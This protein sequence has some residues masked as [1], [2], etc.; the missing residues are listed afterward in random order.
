MSKCKICG[1]DNK[2]VG[3]N[4]L[5]NNCYE[6][7]SKLEHYLEHPEG[8]KRALKLLGMNWKDP[9]ETQPEIDKLIHIIKID[10]FNQEHLVFGSMISSG[11]Y[12][13]D[14]DFILSKYIKLWMSFPK[15]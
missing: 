6:V 11:L 9:K 1:I 4:D 7:D 13:I 12:K 14:G 10:Q 8:R 3:M 5:C 15:I 2:D